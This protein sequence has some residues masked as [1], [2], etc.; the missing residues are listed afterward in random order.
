MG[1]GHSPYLFPISLAVKAQIKKLLLFHYDP[2]ADDSLLDDLKKR[3]QKF[4]RC[5]GFKTHVDLSRE[6]MKITM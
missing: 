4:V 2:A 5:M 3:A 6:G 1:W